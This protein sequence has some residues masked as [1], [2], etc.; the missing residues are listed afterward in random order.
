M[1]SDTGA[2]T[3]TQA[4]QEA[5]GVVV[6]RGT[7]ARVE[8]RLVERPRVVARLGRVPLPPPGKVRLAVCEDVVPP[9]VTD[10]EADA[11]S[12]SHSM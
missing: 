6:P 3:G 10:D 4:G 1:A 8:R 11:P 12:S 5:S 9:G 2:Q 7:M